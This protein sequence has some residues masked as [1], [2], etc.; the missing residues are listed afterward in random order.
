MKKNTKISRK[1][2]GKLS[3][4]INKRYFGSYY[5]YILNR[6]PGAITARNSSSISRKP[7][8]KNPGR[9]SSGKTVKIPAEFLEGTLVEIPRIT[10]R[11]IK[12]RKNLEVTIYK[13]EYVKNL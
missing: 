4:K 3:W 13:S 1:T 10:L 6:F 5:E 2:V 8:E 7:M 11:N 9:F 12:H